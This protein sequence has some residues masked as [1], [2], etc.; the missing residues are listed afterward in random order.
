MSKVMKVMVVDDASMALVETEA[1]LESAG[2]QVI[3]YIDGVDLEERIV[4]ERPDV[5]LL[6]MVM[7]GRSG[8][9]VLLAVRADERT[10]DTR[11]VAVSS[12][13]RESEEIRD[14]CQTADEYLA[15][16]FT[17]EELL[18]TVRKVARDSEEAI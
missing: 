16:P 3:A 9:E 11:V 6:D 17:A 15:K 4:E 5:V 14:R 7:P 2:H 18:T 1:I 13:G 12:K 10:K 8:Y